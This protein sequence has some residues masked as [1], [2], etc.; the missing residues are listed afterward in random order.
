MRA[1]RH[2]LPRSDAGAQSCC[3][4][5]GKTGR[6]KTAPLP[7]T[8]GMLGLGLAAL[9]AGCHILPVAQPDP[10]HFYLLAPDAT[11]NPTTPPAGGALTLGLEPV[12]LPAYLQNRAMA[13]RQSGEVVYADNHRWVEPLDDALARVVRARLLAA[14][15]VAAVLPTPFPIGVKRDYDVTVRLL[16]C[17]GVRDAAGR[18][19]A[20]FSANIEIARAGGG[21]EVVR[22]ET[23]TAPAA[24]W[25][26]RD[27]AALTALLGADAGRLAEEIVSALPAPTGVA[28]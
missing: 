25:D 9:L 13:L 22:R 16:R 11:V 4:L 17:E 10:A 7:L 27:Y 15:A 23:F 6:S 14:P 8:L 12:E 1:G 20:Q 18:M 3:A 5:S 2:D 24:A 26:G 28:H 21:H 19:T